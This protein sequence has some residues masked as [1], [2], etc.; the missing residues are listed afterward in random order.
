MTNLWDFSRIDSQ[1]SPIDGQ[2]L[3]LTGC[4][5]NKVCVLFIF[6]C[7]NVSQF[8]NKVSW[9]SPMGCIGTLIVCALPRWWGEAALCLSGLCLV[10]A[11]QA[12]RKTW[13][14]VLSNYSQM[15]SRHFMLKAGNSRMN[16]IM[17]GNFDQSIRG[18][19][20]CDGWHLC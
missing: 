7:L 17:C 19:T 11:M 8:R 13:P 10:R 9:Q 6:Y 2:G 1:L 5:T 12:K 14:R 16:L 4:E 20:V 3:M 15:E 18:F